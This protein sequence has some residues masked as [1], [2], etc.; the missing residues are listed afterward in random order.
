MEIQFTYPKGGIMPTVKLGASR[1]IVIPKKLYDVLGLTTGDYLEVELYKGNCLLI[2]PKELVDK[3]PEIDKLVMKQIEAQV[4][5][6][7]KTRAITPIVEGTREMIVA[8][9]TER[10][11]TRRLAKVED[12]SL[13]AQVIIYANKV[14]I[15]DLKGTLIS[16]LIENENIAESLKQLF[17]YMWARSS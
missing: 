11:V 3:H 1:Q 14:A 17:E 12:L 15:T 6:G 13:P 2:T 16:T 7:I 10:L 5:R 9:D 4:K 8:H